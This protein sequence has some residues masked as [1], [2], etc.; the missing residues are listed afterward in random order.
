M[1]SFENS[2]YVIACDHSIA[3]WQLTH[4]YSKELLTVPNFTTTEQQIL[5]Y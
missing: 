2:L 1:S 3:T 4:V 5:S